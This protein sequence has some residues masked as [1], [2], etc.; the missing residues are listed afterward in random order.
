MTTTTSS[1]MVC[2]GA[3]F[4]GSH[5]VERLLADG[6]AVEVVDDLSTGS[7]AN[8]G[9]ARAMGGQLRF[10]HLD[11]TSLEFAE[12][13]GLRKPDVLY[14]F[15]LLAP[16]ASENSTV[17][18]AVPMLLSV[19]EAARNHGV[20]KVVVSIAAGLIYGEVNAKHLP[21]KEG[22]KNDAIGVPH[23]MAQTLIDLLGVYREKHGI[24]FTVLAT[25]NVYGLRQREE[26]GVVASF[27]AAILRGEDA[28]IFGNGK[29]T[30]DF[31]YVDDVVDALV[32]AQNRGDGLLINIGTGVQTSVEELFKQL[33]AGT[34]VKARKISAR[35]AD[36]QRTA[37]SNV[38]A[39]IQLGWTPW[40]TLHDGLGVI[41]QHFNQQ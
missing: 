39:K 7:L 34:T 40:T 10:H 31:V 28:Q 13:V 26:D 16:H 37:V 41:R 8:L 14:H 35:P 32:R 29:Q 9:D 21:V 33:A 2:G 22:R 15:A 23:V 6:H 11:V 17:M 36:L 30:R 27:A 18:R 5:L 1:V 12:L 3:G 20:K 4:V 25:T 24:E 19:L 38:R